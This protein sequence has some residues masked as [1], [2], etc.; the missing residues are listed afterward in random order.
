MEAI[1]HKPLDKLLEAS[2]S[3]AHNVCGVAD[4]EFICEIGLGMGI[5]DVA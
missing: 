4:R 2:S 5:S 3:S 1:D